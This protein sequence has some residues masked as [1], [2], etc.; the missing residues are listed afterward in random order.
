MD[1]LD[2]PTLCYI[3]RYLDIFTIKKVAF[4]NKQLSQLYNNQIIINRPIEEYVTT[5][6]VF[7]FHN[8]KFKRINKNEFFEYAIQQRSLRCAVYLY[9]K[10]GLN[11]QEKF[12]ESRICNSIS[13]NGNQWETFLNIHNIVFPDKKEVIFHSYEHAIIKKNNDVINKIFNEYSSVILEFKDDST[14]CLTYRA[15]F[16]L[17]TALLVNKQLNTGLRKYQSLGNIIVCCLNTRKIY[18]CILLFLLFFR[19]LLFLLIVSIISRIIYL[20]IKYCILF[21][22]F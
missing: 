12:L 14:I 21:F 22:Y 18:K 4:A 11:K 1:L 7:P 17:S 2:L 8:F 15:P 10:T 3:C 19:F 6:M 5:D 13:I 20:A 9:F 16:K